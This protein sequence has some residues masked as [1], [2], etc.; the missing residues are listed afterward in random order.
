MVPKNEAETTS[1]M[2]LIFV[3]SRERTARNERIESSGTPDNGMFSGL[4]ELNKKQIRDIVIFDSKETLA[5]QKKT[6]IGFKLLNYGERKLDIKT[7]SEMPAITVTAHLRSLRSD[8]PLRKRH[9]TSIKQKL[10]TLKTFQ[11]HL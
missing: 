8:D 4:E 6:E 11:I 2:G 7:H 9:P 10:E 3:R 5:L 1:P